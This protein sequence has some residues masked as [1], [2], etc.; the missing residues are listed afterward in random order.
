MEA[1]VTHHLHHTGVGLGGFKRQ[2]GAQGHA[3]AVTQAAARIANKAQG[4]RALHLVEQKRHIADGLVDHHIVR[5]QGLAELRKEIRRGNG[6]KLP[7]LRGG[8]GHARAACVALIA[9]GRNALGHLLVVGGIGPFTHQV[10][11]LTQHSRAVGLHAQVGCKAPHGEVFFNRVHVDV[12]PTGFRLGFSELGQPR[13]IHIEQQTQIGM[14]Q[15]LAG[16][17]PHKARVGARNIEV[18][19][20]E[21]IHLHTAQQC[22][23]FKGGHSLGLTA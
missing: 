14:R 5:A 2:L 1:P 7:R 15:A 8:F 11:H 16:V 9:P 13:H 3:A 6:A 23:I 17:K 20:A 19:G 4:L 12:G 21:L 10:G 18:H 22:Q